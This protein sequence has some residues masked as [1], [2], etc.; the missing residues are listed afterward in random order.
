M[1]RR[2]KNNLVRRQRLEKEGKRRAL[3]ANIRLLLPA[4]LFLCFVLFF[5]RLFFLHVLID[6][7]GSQTSGIIINKE[8]WVYGKYHKKVAFTYSYKFTIDGKTY[9]EDSKENKHE[10]GERVEVEYLEFCP[11]ISRI[12]K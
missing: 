12:K 4:M 8:N 7:F 10:I 3:F 11:S 5:L 1:S 2:D 9:T 6:C